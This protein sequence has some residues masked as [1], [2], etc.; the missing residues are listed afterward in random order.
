MHGVD[1]SADESPAREPRDAVVPRPRA[2]NVPTNGTEGRGPGGELVPSPEDP[3][4]R[5]FQCG[6]FV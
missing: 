4:K 3:A 5:R 1:A 2:G 6:D